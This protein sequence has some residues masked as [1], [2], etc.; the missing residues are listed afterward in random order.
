MNTPLSQRLGSGEE[1][2]NGAAPLRMLIADA[3]EFYC[4]A[5]VRYCRDELGQQ[6]VGSTSSGEEMVRLVAATTPDL[7]LLD[8]QLEKL[9]GF[10][11]ARLARAACPR[12]KMLVFT[13]ARGGY[14]LYRIE[15][16]G[17]DAY[18]DKNLNAAGSLRQ[19]IQ[20]LAVGRRYVAPT[21]VKAQERRRT[22]P[23]SFDKILTDREQDVLILI[24]QC[25]SNEEIAERLGITPRT[26]ETF[27][28]RL[29]KK[30]GLGSTPKLI[31]FAIDNGFTELVSTPGAG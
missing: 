13:A 7:L 3:D 23:F 8:L 11:A 24:G 20:Q 28:T 10:E 18:V 14:T 16:A 19:A 9:N 15:E 22:D 29:L 4:A 5:L 2:T 6:V 12:L 21:L 31:R 17:F 26:S 27:R 30:L 25:L 1:P